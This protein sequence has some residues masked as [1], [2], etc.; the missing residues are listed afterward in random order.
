MKDTLH[1]MDEQLDRLEKNP[2]LLWR[3]FLKSK[4]LK[5]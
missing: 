3:R 5:V 4:F 1:T 2:G